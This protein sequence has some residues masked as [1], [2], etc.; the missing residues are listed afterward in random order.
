MNTS[1]HIVFVIDDDRSVCKSLGRL[2]R[3]AGH[4]TETFG[5]L[6]DFMSREYYSGAGCFVLDVCLPEMSGLEAI[7]KLSDAN[8]NLPTVFIS[9][10]ADVPT[11]VRAMKSGAVDYL[12]KPVGVDDL[13]TAVRTALDKEWRQRIARADLEQIRERFASLTRREHEVFLHV[14]SG[15]LNKQIAARLGVGLNTIKVHR[16]RMMQKMQTKTLADLVRTAEKVGIENADAANGLNGQPSKAAEKFDQ[17]LKMDPYNAQAHYYLGEAYLA[18]SRGDMAK[19]H[20]ERSLFIDAHS[21]V[22]DAARK[23]LADMRL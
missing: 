6:T 18:M 21:D 14:V 13:L 17:G 3:T 22:A 2:L 20:Y 12:S 15:Q 19:E 10:Y 9:G 5:S 11:S 4:P 7:Q 16:A 8:Y 1:D 23:R